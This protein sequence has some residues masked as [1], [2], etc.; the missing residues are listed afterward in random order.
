MRHLP[1]VL[2]ISRIIIT[3]LMLVL[4]MTG[5]FYGRLWALVLFVYAAISDYYDGKLARSYDVK[6]R[7]G[8]YLDPLADKILVLGTFA[9]MAFI[10][11]HIVPWWG[12][13]LIALRD[14]MV[15]GLRTWAESRGRSIRTLGI[16]KAKTTVQLVFL[17][18]ML[19]ILTAERI[20]GP[21]GRFAEWLM[22]SPIL[23]ILFLGV[24]AFTFYTGVVYMMRQEYTTPVDPDE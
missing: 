2:T 3:P 18:G 9:A 15:T 19:V 14:F 13:V 20:R 5:T 10:I 17:I 12:V 24:V 21:I 7:L 6:S 4:L 16:A 8:Q 1:N 23:Y 22:D 11:P